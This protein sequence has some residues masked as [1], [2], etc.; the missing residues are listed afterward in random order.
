MQPIA[1]NVFSKIFSFQTS[2]FPLHPS[3]GQRC[4]DFSFSHALDRRAVVVSIH[5]FLEN[6]KRT[7]YAYAIEWI[8]RQIV[9]RVVDYFWALYNR[10]PDNPESS[11]QRKSRIP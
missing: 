10:V 5:S 9:I 4:S 2:N 8:T 7:G 6:R 3:H 1:K 11:F